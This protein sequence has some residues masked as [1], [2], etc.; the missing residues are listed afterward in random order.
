D[1][2]GDESRDGGRAVHTRDYAD[3]VAGAA[4]A[5]GA[6][7]ALE[8][9]PRLRRQQRLHARVPGE[10]VIALEG[11]EGAVVSVD[12]GA[13]RDVLA[14]EADDLPELQDRLALRDAH[15]RHLVA[16]GYAGGGLRA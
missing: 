11:R 15:D 9:R 10:S 7:E 13:G 8:R 3:I 5:A 4:A 2:L 14:G 6:A 16:A 1:L 12:V